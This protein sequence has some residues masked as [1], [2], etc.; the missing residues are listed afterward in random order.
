MS[1]QVRLGVNI[2]HIATLRQARGADVPDLVAAATLVQ[3]VGAQGITM[4]LREDRRHVQ[5]EDM[6]A[7]RRQVAFLNM[8]MAVTAEIIDIALKVKPNTCCL[9]PEKRQELTT[10]GGLDV[11]R[12]FAQIKDTTTILQKAGIMVSL[13]I[14]PEPQ[15]IVAAKEAG[16]T[17]I[18]L[19]TGTYAS[20]VQAEQQAQLIIL[21]QA[22]K[23]AQ[24]I[25]LQTN[26]GHGLNY[27]N[28][29]P[30][31]AISGIRELNIG[32]SIIA[33]AVFVGLE[34]AVRM[35]LAKIAMAY[36]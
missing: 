24:A 4:H 5:T 32:Y 3:T 16:A 9:V 28:V 10:E 20:A 15:Q 23:E 1:K 33:Q 6:F 14:D 11:Q 12:N 35:M 36:N 7:V 19:H 30:V 13:F 29:Q 31:A 17:A 18:E 22:A 27:H 25:G 26:A 34:E 2:D 21:K 8:E